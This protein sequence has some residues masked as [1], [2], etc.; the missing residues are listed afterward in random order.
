MANVLVSIVII[1]YNTFELTSSCIESILT[2]ETN[3][4]SEIILVDNNSS[5]KDADEF[6]KKFPLI[7]LIKSP[8]NVGF[9]KGNTLGIAKS[10][11]KYILLLNS[12]TVLR[13]NAITVAC[14]F[15]EN[16]RH[17]GVVTGRLE[18]PDGTVQHNCQRFPSVIYKTCELFRI[19]KIIPSIKRRLF[20]SFFSYDAVAFPD[21]IWGTFFMFRKEDLAKME[22]GKLADDFF[23]YVED[24]QWCMDFKNIGLISAF[25][26]YAQIVH[27]MGKSKGVKN[28][29]MKA[30]HEKFMKKYYSYPHRKLIEVL[31][32]LLKI[33][34]GK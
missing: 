29:W 16:S 2:K 28:E 20:G 9:A 15:L 19:Q 24:M 21:W 13:N 26:P 30:N 27:L 23:M 18:Y 11:G 25:T 4:A 1:N 7:N 3:L 14:Q 8:I 17:V 10:S 34:M 12:D 22:G 31:D 33:R 32:A 6:K 5:E